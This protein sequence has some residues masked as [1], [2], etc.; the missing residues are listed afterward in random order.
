MVSLVIGK[1]SQTAGARVAARWNETNMR[2][3]TNCQ[4]ERATEG[5][6]WIVFNSGKNRRWKCGGCVVR[7]EESALEKMLKIANEQ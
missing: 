1:R 5:G 3:C 7:Q 2:Y 4:L 6:K